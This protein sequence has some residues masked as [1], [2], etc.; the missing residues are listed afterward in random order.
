MAITSFLPVRRQMNGKVWYLIHWLGIYYL[1]WDVQL[2]YW[3][4]VTLY[5]DR[6]II[7]SIYVTL[8]GLVKHR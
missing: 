6:Q 3:E 2:T 7:D 1:R 8:G 4:E 5:E